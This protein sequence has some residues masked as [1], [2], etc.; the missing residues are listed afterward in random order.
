MSKVTAKRSAA[1][2]SQERACASS[3]RARPA[4]RAR[5]GQV[6]VPPGAGLSSGRVRLEPRVVDGRDTPRVA[7]GGVL[8]ETDGDGVVDPDGDDT[9]VVR[10]GDRHLCHDETAGE[11]PAAPMV[12]MAGQLDGHRAVLSKTIGEGF[13]TVPAPD[14]TLDARRGLA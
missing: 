12:G 8:G 1:P 7:R 3:R 13:L 2:R 5:I 9:A 14:R 4:A 11:T 6:I 10:A